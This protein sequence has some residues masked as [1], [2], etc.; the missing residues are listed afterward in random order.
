MDPLGAE[1]VKKNAEKLHQDLKRYA[2]AAAGAPSFS[3][4]SGGLSLIS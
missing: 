1:L 3:P 2:T 4:Y